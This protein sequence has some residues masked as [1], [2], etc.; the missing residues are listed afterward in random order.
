[1]YAD[2]P[3]K[4]VAEQQV[5]FRIDGDRGRAEAL[6]QRG[7][8]FDGREQLAVGIEHLH[9][10]VAGDDHVAAAFVVDAPAL[11]GNSANLLAL[12]ALK[13]QSV[14]IA[15]LGTVQLGDAYTQLVSN[16]GTASQQNQAALSV[17]DTV[18][19]YAKANWASTSGV[20]EDEEAVSLVQFQQM[21]QANMKV[22]S[23]A[24]TLF[25][26]TLAILR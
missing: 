3:R 22:F 17:A 6:G 11:P 19:S 4:A 7:D 9:R 1:V 15:S 2:Q 16:L 8:A 21:Y 25:D 14:P 13:D 23:V 5:A 24:N 12:I 20:N 10:R 26:A 18:R